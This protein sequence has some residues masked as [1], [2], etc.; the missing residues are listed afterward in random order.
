LGRGPFEIRDDNSTTD[1]RYKIDEFYNETYLDGKV[2]EH[3][4]ENE[5]IQ[6]PKKLINWW[7][8]TD[9]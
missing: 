7:D 8:S 4:N 2:Y 3:M 5:D 6:K 9:W 1:Y